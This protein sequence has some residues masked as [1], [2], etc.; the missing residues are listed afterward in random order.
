MIFMCFVNVLNKLL[1]SGYSGRNSVHPG[2][3]KQTRM[4][5]LSEGKGL[6]MEKVHSHVLQFVDGTR[7]LWGQGQRRCR[8]KRATK[9]SSEKHREWKTSV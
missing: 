2:L 4:F 3:L 6:S 7:N 1:L 9:K 8:E 5:R